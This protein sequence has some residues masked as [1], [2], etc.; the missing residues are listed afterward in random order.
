[1]RDERCPFFRTKLELGTLESNQQ[2]DHRVF[3]LPRAERGKQKGNAAN[4]TAAPLAGH[5]KTIASVGGGTVGVRFLSFSLPDAARGGWPCP[6]N[7]NATITPS[8]DLNFRALL[9]V[10]LLRNLFY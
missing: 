9:L 3:I 6:S 5:H 8:L 1:M 7:S 10:I 2:G 4:D